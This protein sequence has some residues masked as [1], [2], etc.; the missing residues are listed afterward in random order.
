MSTQPS[1]R[2]HLG[3]R[4]SDYVDRAMPEHDLWV[5]DRHVLICPSCGEAVAEERRLLE[6]LRRLD[7]VPPGG[8]ALR[9]TLLG[10]AAEMPLPVESGPQRL[11][12]LSTGA[13]AMHRSARLS[14]AL[15]GAAAAACAVAA[16]AVAGAQPLPTDGTTPVANPSGAVVRPVD[17]GTSMSGWRVVPAGAAAFQVDH[18]H[19][20]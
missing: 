16:W 5:C 19:L 7:G 6:S 1:V 10:L 12:V 17:L 3:D 8:D 2:E 14:L 11:P 18:R 15:A 4:L 9:Q 20:P 13:P